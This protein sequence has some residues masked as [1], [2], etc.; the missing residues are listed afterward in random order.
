MSNIIIPT[1]Y[2]CELTPFS[3]RLLQYDTD[4]SKLFL[5]RS[6]NFFL[7]AFTYGYDSTEMPFNGV[8]TSLG[9]VLQRR[10][11]D[12]TESILDGFKTEITFDGSMVI[13]TCS[14]GTCIIDTTMISIFENITLTLDLSESYIPNGK[15]L[16]SLAYKWNESILENKSVFKLFMV[17]DDGTE[18]LPINTNW[19]KFINELIINKFTLTMNDGVI[20]SN[21]IQNYYPIP[22]H[23]QNKDFVLIKNTI[24]EIC[25]LTNIIYETRNFIYSHMTKK[26]IYEI[27]DISK[28]IPSDSP[29]FET[30][31]DIPNEFSY[32][33]INISEINNKD[34]I[35]QCY[36]DDMKIET[37]CIQHINNFEL[38]IWMPN[39]F[40]QTIPIKKIKVIIIG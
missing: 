30:S 32:S 8:V 21:S 17:N 9:P 27:D 22:I 18:Y 23:K 37:S 34:C 33:S 31:P 38:R 6:A 28:W 39:W 7:N 35:V 16:I 2:K 40:V 1:N 26:Q 24:Y 5:T 4:Q 13:V 14:P 3:Q 36:I 25:P 15:I 19:S 12:R 29:P 20:N 11:Q 10:Y